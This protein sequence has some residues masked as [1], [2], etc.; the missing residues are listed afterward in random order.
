MAACP[1]PTIY[2]SWFWYSLPPMAVIRESWEKILHWEKV[3]FSSGK[4][5]EGG[6]GLV[7]GGL[8]VG[9]SYAVQKWRRQPM[10]ARQFA[11]IFLILPQ[12]LAVV[13]PN[14]SD[15]NSGERERY[16]PPRAQIGPKW[17]NGSTYLQ[18]CEMS[19]CLHGANLPNQILPQEKHVNRNKFYTKKEKGIKFTQKGFWGTKAEPSII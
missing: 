7:E 10:A 16:F 12:T 9:R 2:G 4:F 1:D 15:S 8:K 3:N 14:W 18:S 5:L 17:K 6:L 19:I 11:P 13:S